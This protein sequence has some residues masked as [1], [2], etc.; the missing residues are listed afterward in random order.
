[1]VGTA[2]RLAGSSWATVCQNLEAEKRSH[3]TI[4]HPIMI[5]IN[6]VTTCAL[7]WNS[8]NS[9]PTR[10]PGP[11]GTSSAPWAALTSSFRWLNIAPLGLPVVPEV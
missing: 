3:I 7:A 4:S 11:S 9:I 2:D 5:G 6:V 8:G 1:M 10:S